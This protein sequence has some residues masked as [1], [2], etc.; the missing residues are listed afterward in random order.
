VD[1]S[2]RNDA[3]SISRIPPGS[4]ASLA[5]DALKPG[6][7]LLTINGRDPAEFL[8]ETRQEKN[9]AAMVQRGKDRVRVET[10]VVMPTREEAVT[11]RFQAEVQPATNEILLITRGI[12][13]LRLNLPERWTPAT[14]N[15]NGP[16]AV[17]LAI[18]GCYLLIESGG[19]VNASP[20]Q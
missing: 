9:V 3:I 15:W 8:E 12:A 5:P 18:P 20:C 6:D 19:D 17:K 7:K 1:V 14:V 11:V 10:R 4:G 2:R 16:S 13:G